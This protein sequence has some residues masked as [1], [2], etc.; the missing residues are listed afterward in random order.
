MAPTGATKAVLPPDRWPA[1]GHDR[2]RRGAGPV[3]QSV[4][5]LLR[6]RRHARGWTQE[7]LA[8]RSGLHRTFIGLL[9]RGARGAN[10]D[11]LADLARAFEVEP[12]NLIPR[13]ADVHAERAP[14]EGADLLDELLAANGPVTRSEVMAADA[15]WRAALPS[16]NPDMD[17]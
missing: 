17:N 7:E 5:R 1:D 3:R 13:W 14:E 12:A 2:G 4:G 8:L 6:E 10:V 15:E 11:R 9:E 16:S